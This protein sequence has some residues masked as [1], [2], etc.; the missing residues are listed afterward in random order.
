M[1]DGEP[2]LGN[3]RFAIAAFFTLSTVLSF[4]GN[5]AL[6]ITILRKRSLHT[7]LNRLVLGITAADILS[8]LS[9]QP[10]DIA[11]M[12]HIPNY[13]KV[14]TPVGYIIWNSLYYSYLT[15]SACNLCIM[16]LD[17]LIAV[18]FPLRYNSMITGKCIYSAI[19]VSWLYG[20]ITFGL[21]TYLQVS[22][23]TKLSEFNYLILFPSKWVVLLYATNVLLP[24]L[25][26]FLAST[27]VTRVA[28]KCKRQN[29]Q[30]KARFITPALN[31]DVLQV[32]HMFQHSPELA[33]AKVSPAIQQFALASY[34]T[35][36]ST[37]L[38]LTF[39]PHVIRLSMMPQKSTQLRGVNPPSDL[40]NAFATEGSSTVVPEQAIS[41]ANICSPSA[42]EQ[43]THSKEVSTSKNPQEVI[44]NRTKIEKARY[45][46]AVAS[47]T[48]RLVLVLSLTF[49]VCTFPYIV[50]DIYNR[51]SSRVRAKRCWFEVT[52]F[53]AWWMTYWN[54]IINVLCYI[55]MNTQLRTVL[56]RNLF[57]IKTW[58]I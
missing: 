38:G 9:S 32:S 55:S 31:S 14:F 46:T 30:T 53:V 42:Q 36:S 51:S 27:Y 47:K 12:I 6:F 49:F 25:I 18:R 35:I 10:M 44:R 8:T 34:R 13:S 57:A 50:L 56:K 48:S 22:N 29:D 45:G 41:F 20:A 33:Y 2:C 17:R 54:S 7:N 5:M 26:S 28:W 3:G 19:S 52:A 1:G 23:H 58:F 39:P 43:I 37:I 11:Y 16:N 21:I 4:T 15:L 24:I 40:E